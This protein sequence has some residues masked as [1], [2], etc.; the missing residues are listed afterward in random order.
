M[1]L[2]WGALFVRVLSCYLRIR[3]KI[4]KSQMMTM[5]ADTANFFYNTNPDHAHVAMV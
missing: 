4:H 3:H 2:V 5:T 1:L